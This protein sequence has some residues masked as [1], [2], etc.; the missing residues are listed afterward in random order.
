MLENII[1]KSAI[2]KNIV[3]N[4]IIFNYNKHNKKYIKIKYHIIIL[5]YLL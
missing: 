3:F 5:I 2:Y 4:T 1:K